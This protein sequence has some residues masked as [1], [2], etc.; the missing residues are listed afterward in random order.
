MPTPDAD[1]HLRLSTIAEDGQI[2]EQEIL[3]SYGLLNDLVKVIGDPNV[4]STIELNADLADLVMRIV[5]VPRSKTGR[6]TALLTE[7][8]PPGLTVEEAM[9]LFD[10]V[11]A[12]VLTFFVTRLKSSLQSIEDRKGAMLEIG[13]KVDGLKV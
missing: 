13:S 3:M 12:H 6:P 4:A 8:A 2:S 1:D 11:K 9:K 5:L 7:F 10:W